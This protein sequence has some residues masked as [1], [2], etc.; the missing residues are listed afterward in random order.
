MSATPDPV[1]QIAE[2]PAGPV[3]GAFFDLDGTLVA[4]FTAAAHASDRLR[5]GQASVGE[6]LGVVEASLRDK[7]G[8]MQFE[9][10]LARAAGYLRGESLAELDAAG[11]RVFAEQV[12]HQVYPLMRRIID[13]H[14]DRGHTLAVSSSALSIHAQPVARALGIPAVVCNTFELDDDGMLTGRIVSPIV[15]GRHKAAA[16]QRFSSERGVELRQSYFYADGDEDAPLMKMV[17]HPRPVNPRAGLA[18]LAAAEGWPVLRVTAP[19]Q[20][21]PADALGHLPGFA[22]AALGAA[23]SAVSLRGRSR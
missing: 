11:E 14:R 18:T 12:V 23:L 20:R 19:G 16:V 15:W 17:G 9:R 6:V 2:S 22:R 1:A 13:A 3:V 7:L 21:G 8:R 10:L 4:G 5:R